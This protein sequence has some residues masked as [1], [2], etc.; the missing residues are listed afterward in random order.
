MENYVDV[1]VDM[2]LYLKPPLLVRLVS[3]STHLP[4]LSYLFL[5]LQTETLTSSVVITT[6]INTPIPRRFLF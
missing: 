1:T 3:S 6:E 4:I 2:K 5:N